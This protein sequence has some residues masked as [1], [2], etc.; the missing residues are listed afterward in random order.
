M[1]L[2][3]IEERE[4]EEGSLGKEL[5]RKEKNIQDR[6]EESK[7]REAR[8]FLLLSKIFNVMVVASFLRKLFLRILL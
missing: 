4:N 5:W 2:K 3:T 6:I 7:I 1:G 8:F